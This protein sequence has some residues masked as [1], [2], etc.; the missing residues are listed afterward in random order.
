MDTREGKD[1]IA[2]NAEVEAIP[3]APYRSLAWFSWSAYPI[4]ALLG[5]LLQWS[6]F[7][8]VYRWLAWSV[9]R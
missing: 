7:R 8:K 6:S 5:G 2:S 3:L 1:D 9:L 4:L